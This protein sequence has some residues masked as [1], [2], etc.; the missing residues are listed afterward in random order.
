VLQE[1][2]L[3]FA[4]A[5]GERRILSREALGRFFVK[6]TA[7]PGRWR[8]GVVGEHVTNV[9]NAFGG[10]TRKA[11]LVRGKRVTG[12]TFGSLDQAR[13]AFTKL[14]KMEISWDSGTLPEAEDSLPETR[15]GH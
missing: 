3:E 13:N 12:Y 11:A 9:E 8:N 6:L 10:T 7:K 4:K 14:T 2:Y 1:S 15:D 5:R